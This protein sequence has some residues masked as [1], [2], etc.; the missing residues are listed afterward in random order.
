MKSAYDVLIIGGGPAGL[1][2]AMTLGR[3]SLSALLCDDNKPRNAPSS[4]VNNFP[5]RDGIHP[6][7]WRKETRKNLEKYKTIE[8]QTATVLSV[9]KSTSAF[10]AKLSTGETI[11]A[12]KI[13]LAYGVVDTLP[14]I[15]GFKEL[16]GKSV[17]H[18]PFCHGFEHRSSRIG[19]VGNGD[20]L[21][22]AL[23]MIYTLASDLII[24]TNG[25]AAFSSENLELLKR[26]NIPLIEEPIQKLDFDEEALKDIVLKD[27]RVIERQYLFLSPA[28]PF[29]LKS[30]IGEKLGCEKN[31]FGFYKVNERNQTTV[32]GVY[33]CGDNMTMAHSVLLA[34]GSAVIAGGGVIYE[35]LHDKMR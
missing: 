33:A 12:K 1:T 23:P 18:C 14:E 19:L 25:T 6:A 34:A 29:Q 17:F 20:L 5:S 4:H 21:F 35:L 26:N 13:I 27:G 15:T 30:D 8:S 16:W 3:L 28:V 22:H 2:A 31:Q 11:N 9:E 24:F 32:E 10:T 7:E